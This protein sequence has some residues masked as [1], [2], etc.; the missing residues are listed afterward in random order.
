LA[1]E[2]SKMEASKLYKKHLKL[3]TPKHWV[4]EKQ[5]EVIRYEAAINAINEALKLEL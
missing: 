4:S 3:Q 2:V 1:L 5:K